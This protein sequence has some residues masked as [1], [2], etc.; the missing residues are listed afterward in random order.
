MWSFWLTFL[1]LC[2]I[3]DDDF[4]QV[5]VDCSSSFT[6]HIS[7]LTLNS[8]TG[9]GY[10]WDNIL[11]QKERFALV[12]TPFFQIP[13]EI[14]IMVSKIFRT[15]CGD[16]IIISCYKS[17]HEVIIIMMFKWNQYN[18]IGY[19]RYGKQVCIPTRILSIWTFCEPNIT[20]QIIINRG[21]YRIII[22]PIIVRVLCLM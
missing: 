21:R 16:F 6:W 14:S 12:Y 7:F 22:V 2:I 10:K 1:I 20:I 8:K 18:H 4:N 9:Y 17:F 3:S 11:T 13:L 15:F 19:F 5:T